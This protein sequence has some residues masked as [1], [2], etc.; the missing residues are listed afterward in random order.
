MKPFVGSYTNLGDFE[1]CPRKFHHKH[2]LKD[3]PREEETE[4]M[5]YGILVHKLLEDRLGPR[6]QAL[7]E[8][9]TYLE[10]WAAPAAAGHLT[11]KVEDKLGMTV[12]GT[13]TGFFSDDVWFRVKADLI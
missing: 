7:P 8:P 11:T 10:K 6:K 5:R 1:N 9:H 4:A 13:A 3:L 2:I 12:Q